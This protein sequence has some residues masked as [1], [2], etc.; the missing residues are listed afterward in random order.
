MDIVIPVDAE[1]G[2]EARYHTEE[3]VL[4]EVAHIDQLVKTIDAA[5][6]PGP[7]GFHHEVALRGCKVHAEDIRYRYLFV[8][9]T[10]GEK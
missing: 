2:D 10:R 4:V 1:L 8:L 6:R 3:S 7:S 5:R 9:P